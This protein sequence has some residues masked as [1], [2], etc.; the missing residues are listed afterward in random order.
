MNVK[1]FRG[2]PFIGCSGYPDCKN[3]YNPTKAREAIE[4]GTLKRD[5]QKVKAAEEKY[6]RIKAEREEEE[7]ADK[8]RATGK[9]GAEEAS[10]EPSEEYV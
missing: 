4:A 3:T 10:D 9:T 7:K 8:E 5:E 2:R 6:E 1:F